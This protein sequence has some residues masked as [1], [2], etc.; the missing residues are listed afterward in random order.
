MLFKYFPLLHLALLTGHET[1]HWCEMISKS[2]LCM[3][4]FASNFQRP[5]EYLILYQSEDS[6]VHQH[7]HILTPC[8]PIMFTTEPRM[9]SIFWTRVFLV[10]VLR[11]KGNHVPI[12]YTCL[13]YYYV[14]FKYTST[15]HTTNLYQWTGRTDSYL[16]M[17]QF[18]FHNNGLRF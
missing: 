6:H 18:R 3:E 11:F 8:P 16:Q 13:D 4:P 1:L 12:K 7:V 15:L 9:I 5:Y 17:N 10:L 2:Q 14:Q